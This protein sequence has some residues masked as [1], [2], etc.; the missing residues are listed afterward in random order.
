MQDYQQDETFNNIDYSANK[1]I[2]RE[3]DSCHFL[4]CNFSGTNLSD[5]VFADCEFENCNLSSAKIKDTSFQQVDFKSCKMLGLQFDECNEFGLSFSFEDCVLNHCSFYK[6]NIPKTIFSGCQLKEVDFTQAALTQASFN[7]S[8]LTQA[9]FSK[10]DLRKAKF[11]TAINFS[12]DPTQ[13]NINK[14]QFS[15]TN[16]KGLVD[17][18]GIEFHN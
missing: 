18:F 1:T 15:L 13:N 4:N 5:V 9:T 7:D 11:Q 6:T 3:Y 2:A 12:I 14:A 16:I 8:D 17:C 10:T